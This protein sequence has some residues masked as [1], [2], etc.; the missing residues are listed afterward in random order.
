MAGMKKVFFIN[1]AFVKYIKVIKAR[2]K[3]IPAVKKAASVMGVNL[4]RIKT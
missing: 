2:E 3:L 1:P 4:K